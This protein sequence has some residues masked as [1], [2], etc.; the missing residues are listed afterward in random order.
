MGSSAAIGMRS[1]KGKISQ[2]LR[3]GNTQMALQAE[4]CSRLRMPTPLMP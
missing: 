3:A 1:S 2:G 4:K